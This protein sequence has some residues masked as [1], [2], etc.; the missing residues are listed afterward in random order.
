MDFSTL[1]N[2]DLGNAGKDFIDEVHARVSAL[3]HGPQ[4]TLYAALLN[5]AHIR[6]TDLLNATKT[7][8]TIQPDTGGTDKGDGS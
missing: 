5:R 7:G 6:L 3:S 1:S 2:D 8:G 4:K